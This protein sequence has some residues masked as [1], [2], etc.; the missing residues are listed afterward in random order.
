MH[1][2]E[3]NLS[4]EPYSNYQRILYKADI[5][6]FN[7]GELDTFLKKAKNHKAPGPDGIQMELIK[8]LDAENRTAVLQIV[9]EWWRGN[10]M[11]D[12]VLKARVV[13]IYK[14]GKK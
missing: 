10:A 9:N 5:S 3:N 8:W 11:T 6:N 4:T 14:T 2:I 1:M 7:I 12:D 13:S